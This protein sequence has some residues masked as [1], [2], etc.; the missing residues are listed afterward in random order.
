MYVPSHAFTI[1]DGGV[2]REAPLSDAAHDLDFIFDRKDL[3]TQRG[4]DK[5][6]MLN[7]NEYGE[8]VAKYNALSETE[9]EQSFLRRYHWKSCV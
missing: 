9:R 5:G 2:A 7:P 3:V 8:F 1:Y 4:G 6:E